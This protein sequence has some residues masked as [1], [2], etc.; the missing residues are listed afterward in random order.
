MNSVELSRK[1]T[2][3]VAN[4]NYSHDQSIAPRGTSSALRW[5]WL[6]VR[7]VA[8]FLID[9]AIRRL[10]VDPVDLA[11]RDAWRGR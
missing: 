4:R 1:T 3:S 11:Q 7:A 8:L 10:R 6:L 2:G 9:V 5:R